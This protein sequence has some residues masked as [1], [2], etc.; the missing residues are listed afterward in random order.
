MEREIRNKGRDDQRESNML[1]FVQ[2][3]LEN[4]LFGFFMAYDDE[5]RVIGYALA[6][7]SLFPGAERIHLMRIYAKQTNVRIELEN[8]LIQWAKQ[9]KVKIAQMTVTKHIKAFRRKYN[10]MP[11][12]VNMERRF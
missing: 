12:S 4:P 3:Q 9:F 2:S 5:D 11:V 7:I 10:F 1:L 6:I 8:I